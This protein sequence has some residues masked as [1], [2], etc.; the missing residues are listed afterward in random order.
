MSHQVLA[1]VY[2]LFCPWDRRGLLASWQPVVPVNLLNSD[3]NNS[4]QE[5]F[6][7]SQKTEAGLARSW[8]C[9]SVRTENCF[10]ITFWSQVTWWVPGQSGLHCEEKVLG[11]LSYHCEP[12]CRHPVSCVALLVSSVLFPHWPLFH[13]DI[14][15]IYTDNSSSNRFTYSEETMHNAVSILLQLMYFKIKQIR[16]F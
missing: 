7:L 3:S 10:R 9:L 16:Y 14:S 6:S 1:G 11:I 5:C 12:L 13:P 8:M 4:F 2:G 15:I